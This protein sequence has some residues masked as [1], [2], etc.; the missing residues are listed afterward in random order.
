MK[1]VN[2]K[3]TAIYNITLLCRAKGITVLTKPKCVSLSVMTRFSKV[4]LKF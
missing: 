1:N 3:P 2:P 4:S